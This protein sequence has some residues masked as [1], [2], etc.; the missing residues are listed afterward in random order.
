MTSFIISPAA[1]ADLESIWLYSR[2]NWNTGQADQYV[3][4]LRS[5]IVDLASGRKKGRPIG[6]VRSGYFKL[7]VSSHFVCYRMVNAGV[8]D[9][10]RILHQRMDVGAHLSN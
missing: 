2:K 7:A 8:I 9:V 10:V 1:D 3:A 5:A 6:N 4:E